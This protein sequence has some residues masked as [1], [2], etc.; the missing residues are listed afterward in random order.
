ME[1]WFHFR[2]QI[3]AHDR[4]SDSVRYRGHPEDPNPSLPVLLR[5]FDCPH[6]RR[7]V[8]PR[9]QPIPE[10]VQVPFQVPIKL[11]D[12]LAVNTG[13]AIIRLDSL[14]RFPDNPFRNL[15]RLVFRLWFAHRLLPPRGGWPPNESEQPARFA[16]PVLPGFI[17]T[18]RRS[19]PVSR[20]GTQP[21]AVSAAWGSP[22]DSRAGRSPRPTVAFEATGSHVLYQSLSQ[23]RATSMPY[24]AWAV[25]SSS[26]RLI[27]R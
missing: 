1:H 20:I 13:R 5:Y 18:T 4:L 3:Q 16:P 6:R 19:A 23:A 24:T 8:T 2:L 12:R 26:P 22:L 17:A 14:I 27:P 25:S 15:K 21:L 10:L 7:E 9:R 11:L